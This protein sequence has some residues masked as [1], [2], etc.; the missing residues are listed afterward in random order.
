MAGT[1]AGAGVEERAVA[2]TWMTGTLAGVGTGTGVEAGPEA[3]ALIQAGTLPRRL[4]GPGMGM[5]G[6]G[7]LAGGEPCHSLSPCH[8]DAAFGR[9]GKSSSLGA[10]LGS[11]LGARLGARLGSRDERSGSKSG[12]KWERLA[13]RSGF[14]RMESNR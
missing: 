6:L 11:R 9:G 1:L 4:K 14:S 3:E 10:R 7:R 12:T 2:V 13:P 5:R 8:G